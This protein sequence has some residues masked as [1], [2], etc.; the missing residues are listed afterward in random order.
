MKLRRL[1]PL[2]GLLGFLPLGVAAAPLPGGAQSTVETYQDWVVTCRAKPKS[3]VC[4]MRQVQTNTK[5]GQHLL[6]TELY[7]A[8]GGKLGGLLVMPFGLA[9][10]KGISMKLDKSP[11]GPTLPFSTCVPRGCLVPFSLTSTMTESLRRGTAL[12]VIAYPV[13]STSRVTFKIPLKGFDAALKRMRALA[14]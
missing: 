8:G 4:V 7:D 2:L 9:L 12:N 3:T 13:K 1:A 6:T 14:K 5:T 10:A 11:A